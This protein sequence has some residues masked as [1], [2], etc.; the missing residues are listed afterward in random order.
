MTG[1]FI[2]PGEARSA[3]PLRYDACGLDD[4]FLCNGWEY[5]SR[6]GVEFLEITEREDLH[7]AIAL[8]LVKNRKVLAPK[9]IKFVRSTMGLTQKH[10]ADNLGSTSQSV[11]RWEKG[12][13]EIPGAADKLLRVFFLLSLLDAEQFQATVKRLSDSFDDQDE[14]RNKPVVFNH[15]AD[16]WSEKE[17]QAA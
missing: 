2:R 14:V 13:T 15:C 6:N 3:T 16:K 11:A 7:R 4:I 17:R 9:E 5:I 8:H 12:Q 1:I 10:L